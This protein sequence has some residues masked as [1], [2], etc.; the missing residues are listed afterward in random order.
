MDNKKFIEKCKEI[1]REYATEH[2]DKSD[3]VPVTAP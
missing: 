1:V 2:L 3:N